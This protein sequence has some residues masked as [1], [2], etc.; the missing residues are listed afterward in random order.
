[1]LHCFVT[2]S[3]HAHLDVSCFLYLLLAGF[4]SILFGYGLTFLT[5][6]SQHTHTHPGNLAPV[7][8]LCEAGVH[9]VQGERKAFDVINIRFQLFHCELSS[10]VAALTDFSLLMQSHS[11]HPPHPFA[12]PLY[13][14]S[15]LYSPF[16]SLPL[17]HSIPSPCSRSFPPFISTA[18]I[19]ST[20]HNHLC[21]CSSPRRR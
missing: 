9:C 1:M 13:Q 4:K 12:L 20:H 18:P 7:L 2:E 8:L 14:L 6:F 5:L 16:I 17:L 15:A 11:S 19:I 21:D 10:R 3:T